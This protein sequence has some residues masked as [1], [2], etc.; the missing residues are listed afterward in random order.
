MK[1]NEFSSEGIHKIKV[2]SVL[3]VYKLF[4]CWKHLSP[5]D[6]FSFILLC[7]S[8]RVSHSSMT[9][10]PVTSAVALQCDTRPRLTQHTVKN[11]KKVNIHY[12]FVLTLLKVPLSGS[13][14][15]GTR[16]KV[17]A[18]WTQQKRVPSPL[19]SIRLFHPW[20]LWRHKGCMCFKTTFIFSVPP[21]GKV[22][23]IN[24]G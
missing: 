8:I 1:L 14:R 13:V 6:P 24:S 11:L 9:V 7:W 12:R 22:I 23:E 20:S 3:E 2:S 4:F 16:V 5:L 21:E 17:P 15:S 10:A 18:Q 19:L